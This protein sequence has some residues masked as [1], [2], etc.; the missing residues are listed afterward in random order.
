MTRCNCTSVRPSVCRTAACRL[1]WLC[2]GP[3]FMPGLCRDC[4]YI[5]H[6]GITWTR[7][8]RF[9][10]RCPRIVHLFEDQSNR[11]VIPQRA[12]PPAYALLVIIHLIALTA[13]LTPMT[14]SHLIH[15]ARIQVVSTCTQLYPLSCILQYVSATKLSL[16][17]RYGDMYPLLSDY[18]YQV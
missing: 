1:L 3:A 6:G 12:A 10:V 18:M 13:T 17:R 11:I 5:A 9:V 2:R 4:H 8:E 15:V 14:R 16:T 7:V